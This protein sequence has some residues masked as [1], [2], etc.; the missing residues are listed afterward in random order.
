[1]RQGIPQFLQTIERV[2]AASALDKPVLLDWRTGNRQ[3][4]EAL[5]ASLP[6]PHWNETF[7]Q[8]NCAAISEILMESELFGHEIG[9]FTGA[10]R[11]PPWML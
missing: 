6:S 1:M 7:L 10:T 2:S 5:T 4:T 8:V 9:A 3:G 11:A